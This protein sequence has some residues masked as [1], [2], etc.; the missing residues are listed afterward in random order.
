LRDNTL[1]NTGNIRPVIFILP[2]LSAGGAE[3]IIV[4]VANELSGSGRIYIATIRQGGNLGNLVNKKISLL[5]LSNRIIWLFK[6]LWLSYKLKPC[7]LVATNFDINT[8]LIFIKWALP[9]S[10]AVILR[11]PVSIY[12]ATTESKSPMMRHLV[13]KYLYRFAD[14][15]ILLSNEMRNEFVEN[16]PATQKIIKVVYN[17]VDPQ[18]VD[19]AED[20]SGDFNFK[21]YLVAVCRLEYQKGIDVLISAFNEVCNTYPDYG[22]LVIGNGS[23]QQKL[24]AQISEMGLSDRVRLTGFLDNPSMLVKRASFFVLASRYE[25]MSNAMLE[26]LCMGVPVI[27]VK[28]H[29]AAEEIMSNMNCGFLADECSVSA[30]GNALRLA[31]ESK[32]EVN[33]EKIASWARDEFSQS[34]MVGQYRKIIE[35]YCAG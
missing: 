8:A 3:R 9:H 14:T 2:S 24:S 34:R 10:C 18:R 7:C 1:Q 23:Q 15:L 12:A 27:A 16:Y 11:E 6:L 32:H 5:N 20:I 30:L 19:T 21:H 25:G 22:L 26:A 35:E 28:K 29:T 4:N 33:R 31:L 13:F 17:A